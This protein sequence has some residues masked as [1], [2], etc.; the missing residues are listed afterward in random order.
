M[1]KFFILALLFA[2]CMCLHHK[3]RSK[4]APPFEAFSDEDECKIQR[5]ISSEMA[6]NWEPING[7]FVNCYLIFVRKEYARKR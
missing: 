1:N 5:C 4:G 3:L 6:K 7:Y 2:G